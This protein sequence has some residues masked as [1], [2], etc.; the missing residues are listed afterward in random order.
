MFGQDTHSCLDGSSGFLFDLA[1]DRVET[2][3]IR[4]LPKQLVATE[5]LGTVGVFLVLEVR[6]QDR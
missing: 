6:N 5:L 2:V 1:S 3:M 4:T